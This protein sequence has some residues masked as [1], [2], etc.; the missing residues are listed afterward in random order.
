[1]G[2]M[3]LMNVTISANVSFYGGGLANHGGKTVILDHC[4][5]ANNI[6]NTAGMAFLGDPLSQNTLH[7]TILASSPADETC[8]ILGTVSDLGYNLSSDDS[9]LLSVDNHDL[10]GVDPS[11][12]VLDD[13]GGYT[14]TM[15]LL[16][17]SPAIDSGDPITSQ[18]RDQRGYLRPVDGDA[19][20][21]AVSDIGA[22]EFAS[23]PLGIFS[24]LPILLRAP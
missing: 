20:P 5:I 7:N 3:M 14:P 23:F 9:C 4:T 22:F 16:T 19:V 15:A 17:G 24:W 11:L 1:M 21:G 6:G 13:N 10:I 2:T 18:T 8:V 12:I